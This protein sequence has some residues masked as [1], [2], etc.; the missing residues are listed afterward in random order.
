MNNFIT[1]ITPDSLSGIL[2][3]LEGIKKTVVLLN[4]PTGCKFYHS[5]ISDDRNLRQRTFDPLQYSEAWYFGQPQIP[6][7]YLDS[8]DYIYGSEEKVVAALQH[9]DHRDGVELL[10]IVNSPGAA[11]IGDDLQGIA[12]RTIRNKQ[13]ICI[14]T[15]GFSESIYTG[16]QTALRAVLDTF[17]KPIERNKV[18]ESICNIAESTTPEGTEEM[19][20]IE[21]TVVKKRKTVNLIGACIFTKYFEGDMI[22]IKRLLALC[23]IEVNCVLCTNCSLE[24]IRKIPTVDLNISLYPEYGLALAKELAQQYGTPY[25]DCAPPIGLDATEKML[26]NI[27]EILEVSAT[28]FLEECKKARARSYVFIARVNSLTGLPSGVRFAMEGNYSTA[29]AYG[30]Y[31]IEYFGMLFYGVNILDPKCN[32]YQAQFEELLQQ[33][34]R[35]DVVRNQNLH[36]SEV[37]LANGQT[38]CRLQA[39]QQKFLGI[40][41]A[42]P[43]LGYV[44]VIPKTHVGLTGGLLLTEQILNGLIMNS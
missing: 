30:K 44:D 36:D 43:T 5:A 22:E 24:E 17:C 16:Y 4:G 20:G 33:Y 29:Y 23:D 19:K 7:T 12:E 1:T 31:L 21:E 34:K 37:V 14:E 6:T 9:L 39:E 11:L 42:L 27:C 28:P 41:I 13:V 8:K 25:Y 15:P 2:F 10:C 35:T 18:A 38:H 32:C 3:A 26:C 40:E